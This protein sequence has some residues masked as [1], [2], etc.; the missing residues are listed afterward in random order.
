[1]TLRAR[2]AAVAGLAVALTVIGVTAGVYV[3]VRSSLRGEIDDSLSGRAEAIAADPSVVAAPGAP[4]GARA[5]SGRARRG[6]GPARA[7]RRRSARV[8][9]RRRAARWPPGRPEPGRSA[10]PRAS[11]SS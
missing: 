5:T 8:R 4:G 11:P 7:P 10:E 3:A 1:M 2:I 6:A 9:T